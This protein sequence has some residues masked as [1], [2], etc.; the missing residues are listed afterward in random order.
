VNC[1]AV[2]G[3]HQKFDEKVGVIGYLV[4]TQRSAF[5]RFADRLVANDCDVTIQQ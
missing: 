1:T 5:V 2:F 3:L 4:P